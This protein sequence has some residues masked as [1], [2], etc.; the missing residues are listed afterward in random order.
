MMVTATLIAI[1]TIVF[2]VVLLRRFIDGITGGA[3]QS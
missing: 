3:L 1:P 2:F